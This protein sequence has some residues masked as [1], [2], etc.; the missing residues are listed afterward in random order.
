MR[1]VLALLL[2]SRPV[3]II[4]WLLVLFGI[5]GY[6]AD[7]RGWAEWMPQM[8]DY[9]FPFILVGATALATF[10]VTQVI[11][12]N[13]GP[14]RPLFLR[15]QSYWH[16]TRGVP[17]LLVIDEKT[18]TLRM[19]PERRYTFEADWLRGG[20]AGDTIV[21]ATPPGYILEDHQPKRTYPRWLIEQRL[22]PRGSTF[23]ID[24]TGRRFELLS[25]TLVS[26]NITSD[27]KWE[28]VE[29]KPRSLGEG[30]TLMS[31]HKVTRY[32]NE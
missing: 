32:R 17:V 5:P 16:K 1:H 3:G 7:A 31:M 22:T 30:H 9:A 24:L 4:G 20:E 28:L 2:F 13:G 6:I 18:R 27:T 12:A 25:F 23:T 26:A 10:H 19:R 14:Y 15:L 11:Q 21:F 29:D 8:M